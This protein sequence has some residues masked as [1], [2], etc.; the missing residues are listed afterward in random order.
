MNLIQLKPE[1]TVELKI[2]FINVQVDGYTSTDTRFQPFTKMFKS[3]LP[4]YYK[5]Q[6]FGKFT[7]E[8]L[9]KATCDPRAV[10]WTSPVI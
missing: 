1:F 7:N 10:D 9:S 2:F 8:I 6:I 5:N 3:W 4:L